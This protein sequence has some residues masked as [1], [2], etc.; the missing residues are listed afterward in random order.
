MR[1]ALLLGLAALAIGAPAASAAATWCSESGDS[2][3]SVPNR[4]GVQ[5]LVLQTFSFGG[6]VRICVTP[7][8]GTRTCKAFTLRDR[9]GLNTVDVR[10]SSHFPNRG[11]GSYRVTFTPDATGAKYGPTLTFRRR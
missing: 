10:W 9:S 3:T 2:C 11:A 7:P 6:K 5:R 8:T 4:K 1:A